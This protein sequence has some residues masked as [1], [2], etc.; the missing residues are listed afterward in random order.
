MLV[1][2]NGWWWFVQRQHKVWKSMAAQKGEFF[3][4][5]RDLQ[6]VFANK[7]F[8]PPVALSH[9]DFWIS[10][11]HYC[12][13]S[14]IVASIWTHVFKAPPMWAFHFPWLILI[15]KNCR[16]ALTIEKFLSWTSRGFGVPN[17]H[18]KSPLVWFREVFGSLF[19]IFVWMHSLYKS[20]I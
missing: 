16:I 10:S 11:I 1:S 7:Q 17:W 12:C 13:G 6:A 15:W 18:T 2:S 14:L 19:K 3:F 5:R 4:R 9:C 8:L 20:M